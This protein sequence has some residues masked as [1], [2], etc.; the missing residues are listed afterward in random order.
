MNTKLSNKP[1]KNLSIIYI[2]LGSIILFFSWIIDNYSLHNIEETEKQYDWI[3]DHLQS[4]ANGDELNNLFYGMFLI[5]YYKDSSNKNTNNIGA[6]I[7]LEKTSYRN[8]IRNDV[9]ELMSIMDP[10]KYNREW[11]KRDTNKIS[12][13]DSLIRQIMKGRDY[14][15]LDTLTPK[16]IYSYETVDS[17][18]RVT[19]RFRYSLIS[20]SENERIKFYILYILGSCFLVSAFIIKNN[21]LMFISIPK[22]SFK[23]KK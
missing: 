9:D 17:I 7:L 5:N 19:N 2:A 11:F 10:I 22:F 3:K 14:N 23:R 16:Y 15:Y 12:K 4:K 13:A 8:Q 20:Q 21:W 6:N 18:L 1:F